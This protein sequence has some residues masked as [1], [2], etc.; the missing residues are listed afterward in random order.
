RDRGPRVDP[1]GGGGDLLRLHGLGRPQAGGGLLRERGKPEAA[2]RRR[3][4]GDGRVAQARARAARPCRL[5]RRP[6][7]RPGAAARGRGRVRARGAVRAEEDRP[8]RRPRLRRA[9][10]PQRRGRGPRA[11]RAAT[12]H[13]EAGELDDMAVTRYH[14]YVGELWED[15]NLEEL[16]GELS[17]FLLQSGFGY[18][19][20]EW[21]EDSLQSLHDAIL[22]ALMRR[23]MLSDED[24]QKL[25]DDAD[26]LEQFLQK[27]VER[28]IREGYLKTTEGMP[29]HDPTQGRGGGWG[30]ASPP[31]KFELTEKGVDF[32]GYKTLRDLLGSLGK[33]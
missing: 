11:A 30:P 8:Q 5:P 9:R 12:P 10:A 2:R 28:L 33:A 16:I 13:E 27:T 14:R 4:R 15:L 32:L 17:D 19:E 31:I 18:E 20:G 22:E 25:M 24:L 6:A 26:A 1:G 29:F 3:G 21:D 23:G 7:G